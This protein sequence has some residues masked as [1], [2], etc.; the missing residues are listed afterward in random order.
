[1]RAAVSKQHQ[2]QVIAVVLLKPGSIPKTTSGKVQRYACRAGFEN[3]SLNAIGKWQVEESG[4]SGGSKGEKSEQSKIC[5][6]ELIVWLRDYAGSYIN[7]RLIDERRSIPPH[8]VLDFG[9]RGLLGMQVPHEYGGLGLNN[10]DTMRVLQQL[11]AIDPTL[12]LFVGLNNIL[13]IRPI[14][15]YGSKDLKDE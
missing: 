2:L 15:R 8:I 12:S 3:G 4:G 1:I 11:G 6:S 7:S 10:Y 14:L 9:N 13:G 5:A